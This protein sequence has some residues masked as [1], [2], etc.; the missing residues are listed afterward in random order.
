MVKVDYGKVRAETVWK[1]SVRIISGVSGRTGTWNNYGNQFHL[2]NY[3]AGL[4]NVRDSCFNTDIGHT[5]M[6]ISLSLSLSVFLFLFCSFYSDRRKT[7]RY[8][9]Q[10]F[11]DVHAVSCVSKYWTTKRRYFVYT[12]IRSANS[13]PRIPACV[14]AWHSKNHR[15]RTCADFPSRSFEFFFLSNSSDREAPTGEELTIDIKRRFNQPHGK[16]R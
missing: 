9:E 3:I 8:I 11:C 5:P 6:L 14:G 7:K 16:Q 12:K 1:T 10:C 4:R 13:W 2:R 15:G